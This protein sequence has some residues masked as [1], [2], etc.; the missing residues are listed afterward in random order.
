VIRAHVE[1]WC[2]TAPSPRPPRVDQL[3]VPKAEAAVAIRRVRSTDRRVSGNRLQVPVPA[4][5]MPIQRGADRADLH[6][7][8]RTSSRLCYQAVCGGRRGQHSSAPTEIL[9]APIGTRRRMPLGLRRRRRCR[10]APRE[11]WRSSGRCS[12]SPIRKRRRLACG[13]ISDTHHITS[14][15]EEH[16]H[17]EYQGFSD[18]ALPQAEGAGPASTPIVGPGSNPYP[19]AG[20]G[21]I[22]S[23]VW[24][25]KVWARISGRKWTPSSM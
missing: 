1:S 3:L 10:R 24:S 25:S 4:A 23:S 16:G 12:P 18:L 7:A 2:A 21:G 9:R 17:T 19:R 15:L 20:T 11:P 14:R 5:S 8:D 13:G 6:R 22:G